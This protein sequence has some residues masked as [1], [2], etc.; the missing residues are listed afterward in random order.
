M[1]SF[2]TFLLAVTALVGV[3]RS[4]SIMPQVI[5]S[6]WAVLLTVVTVIIAT[7]ATTEERPETTETTA[8]MGVDY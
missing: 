8:R 4:Q 3:I 2:V 7:D 5:F 1:I 6:F